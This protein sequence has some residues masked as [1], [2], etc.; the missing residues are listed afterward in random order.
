MYAFPNDYDGSFGLDEDIPDADVIAYRE[1]YAISVHSDMP[2]MWS[3]RRSDFLRIAFDVKGG[4]IMY[5][6]GGVTVYHRRDDKRQ[7][8]NQSGE[9]TGKEEAGLTVR[10][11]LRPVRLKLGTR[12]SPGCA[13]AGSSRRSFPGCGRGG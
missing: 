5:H 13:L 4:E 9:V 10:S 8:I 12:R 7:Y 2:E 6:W 1:Q 11:I 3:D